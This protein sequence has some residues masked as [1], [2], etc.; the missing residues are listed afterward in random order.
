M[1][2]TQ[3]SIRILKRY[4][5]CIVIYFLVVL[6]L[7]SCVHLHD[8]SGTERTFDNFYCIV[9]LII[10]VTFFVFIHCLTL[11]QTLIWLLFDSLIRHHLLLIHTIIILDIRSFLYFYYWLCLYR[12]IFLTCL[13]LCFVNFK[14]DSIW[15]LFH[16]VLRCQRMF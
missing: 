15:W 14:F 4:G 1:F 7:A 16:L 13:H 10:K 12:S 3:V 2:F 11:V 6:T 9:E 5:L 8:L